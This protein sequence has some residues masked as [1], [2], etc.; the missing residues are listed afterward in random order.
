VPTGIKI[1]NWLGTMWRGKLR[2]NTPMLFAVGFISVFVIGGLSGVMTASVP[3]DVHVTDT[4]FIVAHIHYVLFGGSV[5]TIYAGLY[6]WFPKITG[7]MYNERLGKLHFWLT[8]IGFNFTFFPMHILGTEG[9]PRRV[10]D[11]APKFAGLNLFISVASFALGASTLVFVYN[12]IVSWRRGPT[13]PGNPWDA[14]TLEWQV[15]S[16]PPIF[17]FAQIPHV[18]GSPYDYGVAGAQHA[19]LDPAHAIELDERTPA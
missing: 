7:R 16:P 2:F 19:I 5:F 8:F 13:A 3:I 9:M 12:V 15:T 10:A 11:Y 1:F 18:V 14:L 4:Y 6:Y 17:N